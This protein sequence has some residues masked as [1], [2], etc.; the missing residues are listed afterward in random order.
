MEV[1]RMANK[2]T[3]QPAAKVDDLLTLVAAIVGR[4]LEEDR[5]PIE[6]AE[7]NR[8]ERPIR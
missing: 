4:V 5:L 1:M 3:I 6:R 8:R 7:T 2:G